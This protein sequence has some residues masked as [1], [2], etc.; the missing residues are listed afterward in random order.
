MVPEIIHTHP[1]EGH[2]KL[3]WGGGVLKAKYLEAMYENK[4]KFSGGGGGVHKKKAFPGGG[5]GGGGGEY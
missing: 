3:R 2:W 4:E 5:G 1:M